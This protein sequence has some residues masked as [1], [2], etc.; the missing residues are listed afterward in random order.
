[1]MLAGGTLIAQARPEGD[2]WLRRPVDNQTFSTFLPFFE[3]DIRRPLNTQVERVEDSDGI[4]V[5]VLSFESV[6]GIRVTARLYRAPGAAPG[7]PGIVFLHGGTGA[8]KD[9]PGYKQMADHWARAGLTT[10]AIDLQFFGERATS[11]LVEFTEEE[12]HVCDD[13][14]A[15]SPSVKARSPSPTTAKRR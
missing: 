5:E 1:M 6:A 3:Y 14:S 15:S 7:G 13:A 9:S 11:L 8:G 4:K 2:E 12:K 10:I